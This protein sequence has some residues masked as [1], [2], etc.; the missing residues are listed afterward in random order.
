MQ[1]ILLLTMSIIF[2][3]IA[4]SLYLLATSIDTSPILPMGRSGN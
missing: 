1:A 4:P 3:M 2:M